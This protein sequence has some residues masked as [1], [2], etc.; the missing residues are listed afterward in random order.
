MRRLDRARVRAVLRDENILQGLV[1]YLMYRGLTQSEIADL[2]GL[3]SEEVA[4]YWNGGS[5]SVSFSERLERERA[6]DLSYIEELL[7]CYYQKAKEGDLGALRAV[8][9]L[10][11]HRVVLLGLD[12]PNVMKSQ[13]QAWRSMLDGSEGSHSRNGHLMEGREEV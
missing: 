11:E 13:E 6:R 8:L 5:R 4:F 10:L 2:L 12:K 9:K 3:S 1:D 7:D